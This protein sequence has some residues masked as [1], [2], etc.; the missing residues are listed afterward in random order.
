VRA[1]I[2]VSPLARTR[3]GTARYLTGLLRGLGTLR[4][5]VEPLSFALG[6]SAIGDVIWQPLLL[7]LRA[8]RLDVLHCPGIRAPFRAPV[9]VVITVHDVAVLRYPD[10]FPRWSRTYSRLAL[11]HLLAN[12]TR[13]IASSAF[14]R[15]ELVGLLGCPEERIRVV[16]LAAGHEFEATGPAAGGEYV[17]SVGTLEPRKN[18]SRLADAARIA[19]LELRVVGARGWGGVE[20]RGDSVRWLGHVPDAELARLY[21]GALCVAYPSLYEGFGLP[22]LEAMATSGLGATAEVAGAA[23]VLVDPYDA[24][25]IAAGIGEARSR[26]DELIA[27]GLERAR[28]FSWEATAAATLAVWEEAVA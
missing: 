19:G 24:E 27:R 1:G 22:V 16:P 5:D 7:P 13:V 2:D 18:L 20:A 26:R 25:A 12:A 8:R 11:P 15:S 17:L 28:D 14:T 10:A 6:A 4:V 9:P 21:R 3:G 23:A